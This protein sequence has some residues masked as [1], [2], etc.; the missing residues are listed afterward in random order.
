MTQPEHTLD[1]V[2]LVRSLRID[3]RL[4]ELCSRWCG[5]CGEYHFEV[6]RWCGASFSRYNLTA[7]FAIDDF[8][9]F[10]ETIDETLLMT[11]PELAE[12][13]HHALIKDNSKYGIVADGSFA[14]RLLEYGRHRASTLQKLGM[15]CAVTDDREPHN[16]TERAV[17]AAFEFGMAASEHRVMHLFEDYIFDGISMAEWRESG[18]PRAREERLR[19][20]ART[21]HAVVE[22]AKKLYAE[23]RLLLRNDSATAKRILALK[24]PELQKGMGRQVNP[25]TVTKHLRAAR[26]DGLI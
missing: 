1:N 11:A 12:D 26:K 15:L 24:L 18:L 2:E 9:S 6:A 5:D 20:G 17:R 8:D 16:D 10:V 21:R 25:D 4:Y 23:E 14:F 7:G 3:D 13:F 22:A 19:H